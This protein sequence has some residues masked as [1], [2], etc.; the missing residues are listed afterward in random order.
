MK[1]DDLLFA[2]THE[3]VHVE[4]Q[5][6]QKMAT[7]GVSAF[8]VEQM[9]DLVFLALPDVGRSMSSRRVVWRN[10]IGEGGQ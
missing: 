7:V 6:G 8:A 10:R 9:T 5:G 1:P 4:E 2:E 3:W